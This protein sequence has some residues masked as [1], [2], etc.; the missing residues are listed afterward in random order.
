[1]SGAQPPSTRASALPPVG[2]EVELRCQLTL[3]REHTRRRTPAEIAEALRSG[4]CPA[5]RAFDQYLP[6]ELCRLSP[7]WWTPLS[8]V[9]RAA[10]WLDDLGVRSVVDIGSGSGKFCVAAALAGGC[11]FVGLEQRPGLV[12][13][14]RA[15]A[16]LFEV[17]DRVR[18]VEGA[19]GEAEVPV[20]DAYYLFNPF[21][22]NLHGPL[23]RLD[24]EV[25]LSEARYDHDVE[26]VEDLLR[27]ARAGTC[28]LTYNGFGG[29]APDGYELVRADL[30][31]PSPLRMWQK[32]A[33]AVRR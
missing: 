12:A 33:R 1:M 20:A 14:A 23:E 11:R 27:R 18:F 3:L 9:R 28:L 2:E 16:E 8:V 17:G 19:L 29:R 32:A 7:H 26:L 30:D 5:D 25:E 13:A 21:G 4:R 10:R 31:L 22:E 6:V 15:L 24:D